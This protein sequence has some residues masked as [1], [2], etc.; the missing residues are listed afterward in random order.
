MRR[1][2]A[3]FALAVSVLVGCQTTV[4]RTLPSAVRTIAVAS[5]ENRT[6]QPV[7]PGLLL[8]EARRAFRLDGRLTVVDDPEQADSVLSGAVVEYVRQPARFDA[9]NVVREYRLRMVIDLTLTDRARNTVLWTERGPQSTAYQGAAPRKLERFTNLV[10][11]P[12]SGLPVETEGDA[13]RRMARE[14]S[15]DMVFRVI[16]GW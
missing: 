6:D 11:V 15:A 1:R 7:L 12:A 9:N 16:E 2:A 14:L 5:F 3:V 8:E 4:K 10:V 13:Q